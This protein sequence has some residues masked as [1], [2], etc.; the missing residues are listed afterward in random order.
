MGELRGN[1]GV[2]DQVMML[3]ELLPAEMKNI[4]ASSNLPDWL[5]NVNQVMEEKLV[6]AGIILSPNE[7]RNLDVRLK[8]EFIKQTG[9]VQP[10][11]TTVEIL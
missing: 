9:S 6:M 10:G 11:E 2:L 3:Y 7:R 4:S 5:E 1:E 8:K